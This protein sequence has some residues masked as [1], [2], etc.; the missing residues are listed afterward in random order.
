MKRIGILQ[1]WS[2]AVALLS[3]AEWIYLGFATPIVRAIHAAFRANPGDFGWPY[4]YVMSFHWVW[5]IP[6]GILLA[7][8]IILKD[9]W[10]SRRVAGIINLTVLLA[11]VALAVLWIW[12]SVLHRMSQTTHKPWRDK[13]DAANPAIASVFQAGK[14]FGQL[15]ITMT[16][17]SKCAPANRRYASFAFAQKL[18]RDK[19]LSAGRPFGAAILAQPRSRAAV[20]ALGL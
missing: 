20:A 13:P 17:T 18:R 5:C 9:R 8:G 7:A 1:A 12:G 4:P 10:C 6:V 3:L 14:A 16:A 15:E 11:G 19:P 2:V